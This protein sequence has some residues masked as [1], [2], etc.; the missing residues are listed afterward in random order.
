[1]REKEDEMKKRV[2]E[3]KTEAELMGDKMRQHAEDAAL[4]AKRQFELRMTSLIE[5]LQGQLKDERAKH[6]QLQDQVKQTSDAEE[7]KRL[8]ISLSK[9]LQAAV[10]KISHACE[11]METGLTCMVCMRVYDQPMTCFPCGHLCC[12]GCLSS[13]CKECGRDVDLSMCVKGSVID[14]LCSKLSYQKQAL[15]AL[16]T[17]SQNART[18]SIK[19]IQANAAG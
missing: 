2:K 14:Q 11:A 4:E 7:S 12:K 13:K 1:M 19:L 15:S 8:L 6:E 17:M 10:S 3:A 5:S 9:E 18:Q 16:D